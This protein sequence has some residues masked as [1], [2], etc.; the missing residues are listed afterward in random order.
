MKSR[1]FSQFIAS[2]RAKLLIVTLPQDRPYRYSEQLDRFREQPLKLEEKV[3]RP[4]EHLYRSQTGKQ[5]L[6][7]D[8][9]DET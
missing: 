9:W 4:G 3:V 1:F 7:M 5:G 2:G 6:G 8:G